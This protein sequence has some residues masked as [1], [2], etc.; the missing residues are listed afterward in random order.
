MERIAARTHR[1]D[2]VLGV[3]GADVVVE[4]VCAAGELLEHVHVL[5][6]DRRGCFVVLVAGLAALEVHVGVLGGTAH[7]RVLRIEGA[8]AEIGDVVV[9]D[10]LAD[11]VIPD[12]VD[13]LHFVGGAEAVE[14]VEE[15]NLRFKRCGMGDHRHIVGFLH[16]VGAEHRETGLAAGHHVAVVAENAET[17]TC[18]GARGDVEHGRRKLTRDLVHV[19]DHEEETLR[20]R[21]CRRKRTRGERTMNRTG[22]AA[23]GFHLDHARNR[24]PDV[25]LCVSGELIA[26]FRHRRRR[27]DRVDRRHFGTREGDLGRG[28]VAVDHDLLGHYFI[29]PFWLKAKLL[30]SAVHYPINA[31]LKASKTFRA[32]WRFACDISRHA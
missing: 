28:G 31:P 11:H 18:E 5:L 8:A 7:H 2:D 1:D 24:A 25:L 20:R 10:H 12:L 29:T 23:F 6:D 13:L 17:L 19:G 3:S 9:V 27:G 14:E 4:F 32:V 22:C 26:G 30:Q 15:R 16:R 21:E